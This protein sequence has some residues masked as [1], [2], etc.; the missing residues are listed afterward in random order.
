MQVN[1]PPISVCMATCNGE[2]FVEQQIAS[3]LCQLDE[4]DELV[5]SDDGSTDATLRII[6]AFDDRRIRLLSGSSFGSPLLNFNHALQQVRHPYIFL[7][8]QD[9]IW[10]PDKVTTVA[11]HL[12]RYDMVVSDCI[13]INAEG[14]VLA[15]SF[16]QLRGTRPG[17]VANFVKNS[18]LGC[19]MA[20]RRELLEL[21]LPIPPQAAMHDIWLGM[22]AECYGTIYF[23]NDK[24]IK[25]RRHGATSSSTAGKSRNT[26]LTRCNMRL[27]LAASLI[28]RWFERR[29][30]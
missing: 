10:F 28:K 19:C 4:G 26:M 15:E 24:L 13:L 9:D 2:R 18:Y 16:F 12:E 17:L 21:A 30:A 27:Q 6:A 22:I 23:C 25:F 20:F 1:R 29:L 14:T 5:I 11:K 8:D 3:I 7:A